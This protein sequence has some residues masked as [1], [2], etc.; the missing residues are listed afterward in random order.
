MN[1]RD[2]IK[3][4]FITM[5]EVTWDIVLFNAILYKNLSSHEWIAWLVIITHKTKWTLWFNIVSLYEQNCVENNNAIMNW[6]CNI[7]KNWIGNYFNLLHLQI[8]PLHICKLTLRLYF[9]LYVPMCFFRILPDLSVMQFP[10]RRFK[11]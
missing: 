2:I 9:Q 10:L 1:G 11:V 4:A 3:E 5:L 8:V 6:G 7:A